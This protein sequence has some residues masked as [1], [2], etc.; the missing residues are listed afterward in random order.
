[1]EP[2]ME[3]PVTD[4]VSW[5]EDEEPVCGITD[6]WAQ[7]SVPVQKTG[8][9]SRPL[10]RISAVLE[11][12]GVDMEE[13]TQDAAETERFVGTPL[14]QASGDNEEVAQPEIPPIAD[15]AEDQ[16]KK[17]PW[18]RS[19]KKASSKKSKKTPDTSEATDG[20]EGMKAPIDGAFLSSTTSILSL[21][22]PLLPRYSGAIARTQYGRPPGNKDIAYDELGNVIRVARI[23][24]DKMPSHQ[25]K[26]KVKVASLQEGDVKSGSPRHRQGL[27]PARLPSL[28]STK[29]M[30]TPP[31]IP[32]MP[33]IDDIVF[34]LATSQVGITP[35]DSFDELGRTMIDRIEV[36]PGV[37]VRDNDRIKVGPEMSSPDTSAFTRLS[38]TRGSLQPIKTHLPSSIAIKDMVE[39]RTPTL[40]PYHEKPMFPNYGR[41]K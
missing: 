11:E 32:P 31:S 13:G 3:V 27:R 8:Q 4:D 20:A 23:D 21:D 17:C 26:T 22:A 34:P 37:I 36:S 15:S 35:S 30:P 6:S 38:E 33:T 1:M 40:R 10:S 19:A 16:P 28:A 12:E 41:A 2:A 7:G 18:E 39:R 24:P 29:M 25:V 14:G 9:G 5:L